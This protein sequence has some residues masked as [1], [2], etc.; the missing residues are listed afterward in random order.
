MGGEQDAQ[1]DRKREHPLAHRHARDD[2]VDQVGS[3]LR[4]APRPT[5]GAKP[6][7]LTG[8]GHQLLVRATRAQRKRRQ[9]VGEDAA[10]EKGI[11][12]VFDKLR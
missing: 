12:L 10:F 2:A 5:G 1:R 6:A 4:H 11:E 3:A 7:P 9:A 8:E